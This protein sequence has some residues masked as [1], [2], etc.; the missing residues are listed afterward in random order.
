MRLTILLLLIKVS[1]LSQNLVT[2]I[3]IS[4]SI[5]SLAHYTFGDS[6]LISFKE[7]ANGS[8]YKTYWVSS[9]GKITSTDIK[10]IKEAE[11]AS[12]AI[13]KGSRIYFYFL[14]SGVPGVPSSVTVKTT[15][16][17]S[18]LKI[19]GK[20]IGSFLD[21]ELHILTYD[22][23]SSMLFLYLIDK[24]EIVKESSFAIPKDQIKV[25]PD[26]AAFIPDLS[27]LPISRLT[28]DIKIYNKGDSIVILFDR[29]ATISYQNES[30][31]IARTTICIIE[32]SHNK[33]EILSLEESKDGDFSSFLFE[34]KIYRIFSRSSSFG[35]KVSDLKG[36]SVS[37]LTIPRTDDLK[38]QSVYLKQKEKAILKDNLY[39]MIRADA[40]PGLYVERDKQNRII[41]TWGS[42]FN[43]KGAIAPMRAT[44][45]GIVT[46]V[47]GTA[48]IQAMDGPGIN[49]YFYLEGNSENNFKFCE[50]EMG[51]MRSEIDSFEI[52]QEQ[53]GIKYSIK[54]YIQGPSG[55]FG[56]YK[57]KENDALQ[58]ISFPN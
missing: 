37:Q 9:D 43:D 7:N 44:P 51:I 21:K 11:F 31:S 23:K 24:N 57:A 34:G 52:S 8:K 42:Y 10:P 4:N 3:P 2:E 15:S 32:K 56:I 45:A 27:V 28:S 48:M 22:N 20:I 14:D 29:T 25:N 46:A 13:K 50:S 55:Y 53:K 17:E 16:D 40:T 12:F 6:I 30:K 54:Y 49:R 18:K 36:N 58:L 38:E 41:L 26:K 5:N 1:A 39:K 33:N 19:N 35:L 47:V